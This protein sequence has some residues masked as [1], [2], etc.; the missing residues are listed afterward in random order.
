MA[1]VST[2]VDGDDTQRTD[3][4]SANVIDRLANHDTAAATTMATASASSG[5]QSEHV[6]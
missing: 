3:G 5:G 6:R 2:K 1:T 4:S